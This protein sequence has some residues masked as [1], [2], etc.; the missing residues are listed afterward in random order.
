MNKINE[1]RS[2]LSLIS[3]I[4][5]A[6]KELEPNQEY[7]HGR[8]VDALAEH[9]E[10]VTRGEITRLLINIPPGSSKSLTAGVFWPAWEWGPQNMPWLRYLTT[11][12]NK[13]YV[14][15]D[16]RKMRDLVS[17]EWYQSLWGGRVQ[18]VRDG[19]A[20]FENS[21]RG[22]R[23]GK[24]FMS[25]TAGRGDRVICDDPHSVAT[26]ESDAER[27][28]AVTLFKEAIFNRLND[29]E[30]SAII[31]IG[32]RLH[33]EDIS[34]IILEDEM[35]YVH[36]CLPMEFDPKR[37]CITSIGF[38]DWREEE[39][40]LLFPERFSQATIDRDKKNTTKYAWAAQ[41]QQDP[42][43]RGGILFQVDKIQMRRNP[44]DRL[45]RVVRYWDK[46]ATPG[47]GDRSAGVKLGRD[48][49]RNIWILDCKAGQWSASERE[50]VI[51]STAEKDGTGVPIRVEQSGGDGGKESAQATVKNL[52]G[53]SIEAK[54]STGSKLDRAYPFADQVESGNVYCL[55]GDWTDDFINELRKFPFSDHDDRV[56]AATGAY[57]FLT[58]ARKFMIA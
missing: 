42:T 16:S 44:P 39:G 27:R 51:R 10:A 11:S 35:E 46:A 4:R 33:S 40:E 9:L 45:D 18:L 36:L 24:P 23:E 48:G 13:G 50:K 38:E 17:S 54:T 14:N 25:M 8:H 53:F 19:E 49:E 57:G 56:D 15:R 26:A 3:F 37:K 32:Q 29:Q 21:V 47:A 2:E 5:A 28:R 43:P 58:G 20:S 1:R 22:S 31:V 30:K 6:W 55:I 7:V 12:Y 34:G 52:Q 41:Y